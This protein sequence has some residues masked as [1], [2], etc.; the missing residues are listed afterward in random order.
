MDRSG[1]GVY[2]GLLGRYVDGR[3]LGSMQRCDTLCPFSFRGVRFTA[4][5]QRLRKELGDLA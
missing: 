2:S 1:A 5:N 3:L 4:G